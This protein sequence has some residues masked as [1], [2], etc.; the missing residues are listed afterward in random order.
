[1][2]DDAEDW[3]AFRRVMQKAE[4]VERVEIENDMLRLARD[5]LRDL[6]A[7]AEAKI[8]FLEDEARFRDKRSRRRRPASES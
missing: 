8:A 5:T 7:E 3:K 4:Y 2:S 6:L 1:L